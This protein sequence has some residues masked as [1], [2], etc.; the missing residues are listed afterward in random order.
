MNGNPNHP[1]LYSESIFFGVFASKITHFVVIFL[2]Q[3]DLISFG[4]PLF[5]RCVKTEFDPFFPLFYDLLKSTAQL[6]LN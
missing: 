3:M 4:N 1:L 2:F 5:A 6:K